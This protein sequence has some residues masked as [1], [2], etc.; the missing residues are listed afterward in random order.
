VDLSSNRIKNIYDSAFQ[1]LK[2]LNLIELR[3]NS[4]TAI[5]ATMFSGLTSLTDLYLRSNRIKT[6]H[7]SAFHDLK[8]LKK[9]WLEHNSITA[10]NATTFSGLISLTGLRLSFNRIKTIHDSAFQGLSLEHLRLDCN[11]L[12]VI[13]TTTFKGIVRASKISLLQNPLKEIKA[14]A[15]QSLTSLNKLMVGC[16]D[17]DGHNCRKVGMTIR[18]KAFN[19][20]LNKFQ[21]LGILG[22]VSSTEKGAFDY[23]ITDRLYI[24][25]NPQLRRIGK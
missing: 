6:I 17:E 1:G 21:R 2:R 5:D 9:L 12:E 7:D 20:I 4:L 3:H 10:I 24:S 16:C 15:F 14:L 18:R 23:L 11:D 25:F 13:D 8:R 22:C 19:S